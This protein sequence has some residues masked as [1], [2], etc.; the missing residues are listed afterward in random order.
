[1][2][3]LPTR[4]AVGDR[5]SLLVIPTEPDHDERWPT[6]GLATV[7]Y[8]ELLSEPGADDADYIDADL[9]GLIVSLPTL[10]AAYSDLGG[11]VTFDVRIG[12]ERLWI[13]P[14]P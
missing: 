1:M 5:V 10:R 4:L 7:A 11:V 14:C 8:I 3:T 12:Y 2:D 9:P 6:A 13:V